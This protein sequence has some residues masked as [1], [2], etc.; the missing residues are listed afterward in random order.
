M[1]YQPIDNYAII[2]DMHSAALV[3]LDGSI[4]WLCLPRFDSPSVF[5]RILDD[6]KG[7]HFRIHPAD[8][9]ATNSKQ[10]YWPDTN[11]LVTRFLLPDA[12]AELVDFMPVGEES[13]FKHTQ[14]QVIR[15][16]TVDRGTLEFQLV[17]RPAF[18]YARASHTVH[19]EDAGA[20]F[21]SAS[22]ALTLVSSVPLNIDE[23]AA[24]ASFT[25]KDGETATFVLR[26]TEPDNV[27]H[28]LHATDCD[29]QFQATVDYWR[30]WLSQS[31]YRGRWRET[32]DRSA[33]AL[34]LMTYAPTGAIV[35]APTC[36]L[37]EGI[38]GE[39]NWDYRYTWLRDS[40][41]TVFALAR[42]G[43]YEESESFAHFLENVAS[44][45]N[46]D[47][48]L[49]I[50]YG[51]DGR[52][53]LTEETLDHLDGYMG[54]KPVRIGNGAYNQL[55]LD[56]YGEL[57]DAIYLINREVR[58]VGFRL[59]QTIERIIAFVIG[60]W[61]HADEGIWETRGGRQHFVYSKLMCWVAIDRALKIADDRS[62]PCDRVAWTV[63]RDTIYREIMDMGWSEDGKFFV[64]H[65]GSQTLDASNLMMIITG[66]LSPNEPMTEEMLDAIMKPP[67]QGGLLSNSL[68]YRYN[69][70]ETADGLDGEEGTFNLCTFWLVNALARAGW[71]NA[72][73]RDQARLIFE[74]ML[75]FSNHVG[76]YAEETGP[77]GQGLGNFPQAFTHLGLIT[78]ALNLHRAIEGG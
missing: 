72:E 70:H 55:Q 52:H 65:Y 41:F 24:R 77:S 62:L 29:A 35:A 27:E 51:I 36:S 34:K 73:R 66:F 28:H 49:Q 56:I 6:K 8:E 76:L 47:G 32:V 44:H 25:L 26:E 63:T 53:D 3:G 40:A 54:S 7:G 48:S 75:G 45:P 11:V 60:N 57:M 15:R 2:G 22:V 69:V 43:F 9:E 74:R 46:H 30:K 20:S 31:T 18:D 21:K 19:R 64:Q 5:A 39:R 13:D 61:Q 42:L 16:L 12:A 37:P 78:A 68:V 4:D 50:M 1:A 38:G 14:R 10:L 17:C 67:A 23:D 33:L 59:W 58:P 71:H